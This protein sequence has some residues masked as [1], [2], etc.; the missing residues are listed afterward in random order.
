MRSQPTRKMGKCCPILVPGDRGASLLST[1][2]WAFG[3]A[4]IHTGSEGLAKTSKLNKQKKTL[5]FF[6]NKTGLRWVS[7]KALVSST[8]NRYCSWSLDIR[9]LPQTPDG[10]AVWPGASRSQCFLLSTRWE[11]FP[12]GNSLEPCWYQF[13]I[14]FSIT[15][16]SALLVKIFLLCR[17]G[18]LESTDLSSSPDSAS[19]QL[20]GL[21][22]LFYPA[23][24]WC[25]PLEIWNIDA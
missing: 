9:I 14:T 16:C 25:P 17:V 22:T 23:E 12:P 1:L 10:L 21:K 5:K 11:L 2:L 20:C 6:F 4:K 18:R 15:S 24:P 19:C 8:Q 3:S 13:Y 7:L